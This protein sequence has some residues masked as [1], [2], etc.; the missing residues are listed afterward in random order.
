MGKLYLVCFG[1]SSKTLK[2]RY[3]K[4]IQNYKVS[5]DSLFLAIN[6]ANTGAFIIKI[7]F[8][9]FRNVLKNRSIYIKKWSNYI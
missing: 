3:L 1:I 7:L 6:L 4:K 2:N 5:F 9:K 8:E